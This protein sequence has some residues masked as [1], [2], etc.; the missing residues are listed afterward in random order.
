MLFREMGVHCNNRMQHKHTA[1]AEILVLNMAVLTVK[2]GDRMRSTL[3]HSVTERKD[4]VR[5]LV[6]FLENFK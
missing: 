1:R 6:R 4:A 2:W 5:F 3:R